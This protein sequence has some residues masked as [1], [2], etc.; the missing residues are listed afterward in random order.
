MIFILDVSLARLFY[1][2]PPK[3]CSI[4]TV[5]L[6]LIYRLGVTEGTLLVLVEEMIRNVRSQR[7]KHRYNIYYGPVGNALD[8]VSPRGSSVL[9]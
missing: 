3:G 8:H 1:V 6:K 4:G 5:C 2:T 7:C 9:S